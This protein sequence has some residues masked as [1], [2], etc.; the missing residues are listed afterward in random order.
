V[1]SRTKAAGKFR[2]WGRHRRQISRGVV[3]FDAW[4]KRLAAGG[5]ELRGGGADEAPECYKR[6][7]EVLTHHGNT[8]RILHTL[9]PIGVA[10]A[11]S[12]VY[13]A[14]RD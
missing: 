2:G 1:M 6:L 9:K 4:K 3:N 8:V 5:I 11:G 7:S 12:D 13:D 10:M 14:F